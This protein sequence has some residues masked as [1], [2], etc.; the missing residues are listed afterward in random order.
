MRSR[1]LAGMLGLITIAFIVT[2][3]VVYLLQLSSMD[4]RIDDSLQRSVEEFRV[5]AAR[6][7]DPTVFPE[8][9]TAEVLLYTAMQQTLPANHEGML[10]IVNEKVRWTAPEVVD[11]RLEN[12]P[13]FV[14]WAAGSTSLT[15]V[16]VQSVATAKTTY[17]AVSVPVSL[18][19]QAGPAHL[20]FAYDYTA[21]KRALN[22]G[23]LMYLLV[24]LVV[25][26]T[27]GVAGWLLVGRILRPITLLRD[28]A[29]QISES[30]LSQRIEV[31]GRDDLAELTVTVNAMLD[32]LE[33]AMTSQRQ[34]LD[35]VGHE[36]RTPVTIIQ[37]HLELMDPLDPDDVDQSRD[38]ALA[39]LDRMS[40]LINDL[41]TLAKSNRIDFVQ[42]V[43]TNVG[44]LLDD[45][46]DK[47][48]PLGD[49]SWKIGHRNEAVAVLDPHR[50]TQAMLQLCSNAVKFSAPGSTITLGTNINGSPDGKKTLRFWV[51]DEGIG[52]APED[53]ERIFERFGRGH[54]SKR[55]EGSGLGL[56]IVAA[57]A[58]AHH[59]SVDVSSDPGIG[60]TFVVEI[61][62]RATGEAH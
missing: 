45:L 32:R 13:E 8:P 59:G 61:P 55:T 49:R 44:T 60:S 7:A 9:V 39:E 62:L 22:Q 20:I 37:G 23:F 31:V 10:S 15:D 43:A 34:L 12:D 46:L 57:I 3:S 54:N 17:R 18:G 6:H 19:D 48:H 47:A 1:V 24:G 21:E 30:D 56:N 4:D 14:A 35:D 41:V 58:A 5:L 42:P 51:R 38:I 50:I 29:R 27:A 11:L 53:Q 28:T 16:V 2:G 26:L 33:N 25:L 36:L 40:F 52:I